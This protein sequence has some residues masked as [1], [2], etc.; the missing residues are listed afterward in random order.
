MREEARGFYDYL[1]LRGRS[2]DT[3]YQNARHVHHFLEWLGKPA[4]EVTREDV[5]NYVR[6]LRDRKGYS[7]STVKNVCYALSSF[8]GYLGKRDLAEWV[9]R[10]VPKPG[11]VRWLPEDV[12]MRVVGGDP[13]LRVAY[14]LALRV[15]ELLLLRRDEYNP[16]TGTIA[17]YRLKHKGKPNRYILQLSDETRVLLNDYLESNQCPDGRVFCMSR[18]AVQVRFRNALARAGLDPR[19]YTFHVL[20]HSRCTNLVIRMLR[21]RGS[22]D[23]LVLSK[24]MGHLSPST[25]MAYV[26]IASKT[27]GVEVP[28]RL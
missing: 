5:M 17:V 25:T 9:P 20:R 8:F 22:V 27:L 23:L 28:I 16:E 15:S 10:P 12:V 11:E 3:A 21:E 7:T 2:R 4:T 13:V 26:H 6:Y 14:E 18:K 24:F 19:R 1:V